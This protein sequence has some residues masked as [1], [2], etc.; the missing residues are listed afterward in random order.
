MF[1]ILFE[2][3]GF[4]VTSFG[5]LMALAFLAA[6]WV[7]ARELKQAGHNP[8][9]AW[10]LAGWAAI[11]GILGAKIYYLILNFSETAADPWTALL[12][13][14]GLVWYGGFIGGALAVLFRLRQLK[15]PTWPYGDAIAPGLA[16]GYAIGRVGCFLVGDDY[17]APTDAPWA[18]AFP[19]GAPPSTAGNLRAFGV[20]LPAS[21]PDTQVLA[22]HPTQLYEAGM[23]FLILLALFK[24]R[25]RLADTP[26]KLFFA[27][28]AMA[29]VER[30]IVEI[31]RAK[32]DRFFGA[33]SVAQLISLGLVA[34]GLGVLYALNKRGAHA[35][36]RVARA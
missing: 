9:H 23:S 7:T 13:R 34:T 21:V 5:L 28:L 8:E 12:S 18:V 6:S 32:D 22:V 3:G 25:P 2:I 24:L 14:S 31:F 15:L 17:G 30:F 16:T 19:Q 11:G 36:R 10:D 1:P 20:D 4:Q 29:G 35:P 33:I 26:G 27:W